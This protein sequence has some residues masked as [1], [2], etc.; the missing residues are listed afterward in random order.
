[1]IWCSVSDS[2]ADDRYI[3]MDLGTNCLIT[4]ETY[5]KSPTLSKGFSYEEDSPP[6]LADAS[7]YIVEAYNTHL[8]YENNIDL[9]GVVKF[10]ESFF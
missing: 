4:K 6:M 7:G 9:L 2:I 3:F 8:P 1:M 5:A 10:V